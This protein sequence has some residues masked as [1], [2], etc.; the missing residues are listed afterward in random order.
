MYVPPLAG[1]YWEQEEKPVSEL[2]GMD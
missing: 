2:R 1:M